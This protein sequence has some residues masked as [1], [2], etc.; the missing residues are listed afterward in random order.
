MDWNKLNF[1]GTK[2]NWVFFMINKLTRILKWKWQH[3]QG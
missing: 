2:A 1:R 3:Q